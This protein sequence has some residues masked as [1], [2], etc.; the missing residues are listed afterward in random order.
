[1]ACVWIGGVGDGA[2]DRATQSSQYMQSCSWEDVTDG[3]DGAVGTDEKRKVA[4]VCNE[5]CGGDDDD[6]IVVN[7]I[8]ED[9]S[10]VLDGT[11]SVVYCSLCSCQRVD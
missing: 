1:M 7:E 8:Q 2:C 9:A 5:V 6:D 4:F 11:S 10:E 3:E